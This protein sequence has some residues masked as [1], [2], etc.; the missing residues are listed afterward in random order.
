MKDH[1]SR[2]QRH[3][4]AIGRLYG[5]IYVHGVDDEEDDDAFR[6]FKSLIGDEELA[7]SVI[8][9][10]DPIEPSGIEDREIP[11]AVLSST[12]YDACNQILEQFLEASRIPA[13]SLFQLEIYGGKPLGSTK[14]GEPFS[15]RLKVAKRMLECAL[16]HVYGRP[17]SPPVPFSPK[18]PAPRRRPISTVHP[19]ELNQVRHQLGELQQAYDALERHSSDQISRVEK[20]NQELRLKKDVL[21]AEVE[22]LKGALDDVRLKASQNQLDTQDCWVQTEPL[23]EAKPTREELQNQVLY[24][25]GQLAEAKLAEAK[26]VKHIAGLSEELSK[27][28]SPL[29]DAQKANSELKKKITSLE[30]QVETLNKVTET[31]REEDALDKAQ[32]ELKECA[33][34][35]VKLEDERVKAINVSDGL[36]KVQDAA[37]KQLAEL[38]SQVDAGKK[39]AAAEIHSL[40]EA[41]TEK[42]SQIREIARA[43]EVWAMATVEANSL[44]EELKLFQDYAGAIQRDMHSDILKMRAENERASEE[45]QLERTRLNAS[46]LSLTQCNKATQDDLEAMANQ[47]Y[48]ESQGYMNRIAELE[49]WGEQRWDAIGNNCVIA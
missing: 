46:I 27:A 9:S 13:L 39:R 45:W 6:L 36:L 16:D 28:K 25:K 4:F 19:G 29:A 35:K 11:N 20:S 2:R 31:K 8:L 17:V 12:S 43:A 14:A 44:K 41:L 24:L 3:S 34:I 48:N 15:E 21:R 26:A 47:R 32:R 38:K 22:S 23:P 5:V 49:Q 33:S 10:G 30:K 18:S 40:K 7:H 42:E 37:E 1:G